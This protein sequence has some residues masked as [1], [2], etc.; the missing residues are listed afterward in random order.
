M[1]WGTKPLT[2][3]TFGDSQDPTPLATM[4]KFPVIF[5]KLHSLFLTPLPSLS[6]D[7]LIF[8]H[9]ENQP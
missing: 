9:H 5:S 1:N 8:F 2:H 3:G 7:K 6:A 4:T